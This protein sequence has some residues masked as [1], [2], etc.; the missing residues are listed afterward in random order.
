MMIMLPIL[1]A[2]NGDRA[3]TPRFV[4]LGGLDNAPDI[5]QELISEF[6]DKEYER[7]QLKVKIK[8]WKLIISRDSLARYMEDQSE[9]NLSDLPQDP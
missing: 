8:H 4:T 1:T 2:G 6:F 7:Y 5:K 9:K 3:D